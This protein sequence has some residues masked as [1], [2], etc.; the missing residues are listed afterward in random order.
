MAWHLKNSFPYCAG[1]SSHVALGIRSINGDISTAAAQT[2][3]VG[4]IRHRNNAAAL[5]LFR[6]ARRLRVLGCVFERGVS[7]GDNLWRRQATSRQRDEGMDN[8]ARDFLRGTV[9]AGRENGATRYR[10]RQRNWHDER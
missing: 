4:V 5:A 3:V 10:I 6:R 8:V 9:W 1:I 7:G 2:A